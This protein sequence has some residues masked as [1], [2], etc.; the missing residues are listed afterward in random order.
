MKNNRGFTLLEVIAVVTIIAMLAL[1]IVPI[2]DKNIKDAQNFADQAQID[3]FEEAAYVYAVNYRDDLKS[4]LDT[5]NVATVSL[6]TLSTKGLLDLNKIGDIPLTNTVVIALVDGEIK[7][8]YDK[9]QDNSPIIILHGSQ[10]LT[11]TVHNGYDELGAMVVTFSPNRINELTPSN[12][13]SGVNNDAVGT[14]TVNYSYPGADTVTRT[15][16]VNSGITVDNQKPM[17]TLTPPSTLTIG[18]GGTYTD[19]GVTACDYNSA[20]LCNISYTSK[21]IITGTVNT[22]QKGTYYI[23]YD[24]TDLAGNKADTVVRTV[25]IN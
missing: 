9:N 6:Q 17:I 25:I 24:V 14:Y 13:D 1:I 23:K 22:K 4:T 18:K 19:P 10:N 3:T 2:V 16:V 21:V 20:G 12:I 7:T 15:V 11:M 5:Y 8:V